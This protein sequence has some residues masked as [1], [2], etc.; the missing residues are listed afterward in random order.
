M[1]PAHLK[2]QI[3]R[4]KTLPPQVAAINRMIYDTIYDTHRRFFILGWIGEGLNALD[5]EFRESV[6]DYFARKASEAHQA[7]EALMRDRAFVFN[8]KQYRLCWTLIDLLSKFSHIQSKYDEYL[9]EHLFSQF[10]S[11]WLPAF[12]YFE[13]NGW[14]RRWVRRYFEWDLEDEHNRLAVF[15]EMMRAFPMMDAGDADILIQNMRID[16]K[17]KQQ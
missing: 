8:G 4:L 2:E 5:S 13:G 10:D 7:L 11:F 3:Q 9:P 16:R 14:W 12:E 1:I 17:R 6:I 15:G